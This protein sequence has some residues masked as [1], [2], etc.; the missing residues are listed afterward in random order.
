MTADVKEFTNWIDTVKSLE[1]LGENLMKIWGR[2]EPSAADHQDM[3]RLALSAIANAYLGH[4][5]VDPR[6]PT[7]SPLWNAAMNMGGPVPDYVY[8]L[9]DVEP[10]GIYRLSGY[11][12]TCLF[13]DIT[14]RSWEILGVSPDMGGHAPSHDLNDLT[15]GPD[16]YFSVILSGERPEGYTGDW[17]PLHPTTVK[18]MMRKASYDWIGEVD[19][20]VAI[21]RVDDVP[22]A[23]REEIARRISNVAAW[24]QGMIKF[25]IEL[26]RYYHDTHTINDLEISKKIKELGG[27]PDQIYYDGFYEID[28]DEALVVDTALPATCRYWSILVAD[29]RF[30]TV[31]W[32]NR[33][34]SINGHQARMDPDGRFRAVISARDPGIHN[35]LDKADNPS[36][37]MQ[38][39]WNRASDSPDPIVKKVPFADI[40]KYLPADTPAMSL[41]ERKEQL[42]IRREGAQLRILW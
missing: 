11:R 4:V 5:F 6:R 41:E 16:G 10:E 36:G 8:M 19:A 35:W 9:A 21:D 12:G 27:L 2:S 3:Y 7:W 37:M 30:S 33:Q 14:Q 24:A 29:D 15:L 13:V 31:D 39:R 17:W 38:L 28:D 1:P 42:R 22:P 23:S 20:R 40:R 34:S 26:A 25:D 32:I 18:L